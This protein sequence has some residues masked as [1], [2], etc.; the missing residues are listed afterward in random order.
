MLHPIQSTFHMDILATSKPTIRQILI[1]KHCIETNTAS[2]IIFQTH[3]GNQR[4]LINI[5]VIC[6]LLPAFWN[7]LSNS[8]R[9][10]KLALNEFSLHL[11]DDASGFR[12]LSERIRKWQRRIWSRLDY[13]VDFWVDEAELPEQRICLVDVVDLVED[14]Y[15]VRAVF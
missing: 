13:S 9:L 7:H 10:V 4:P 5:F 11:S 2:L 1:F 14:K 3:S 8:I 6:I 12:A 15:C